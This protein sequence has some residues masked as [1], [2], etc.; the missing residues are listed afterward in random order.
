MTEHEGGQ[1]KKQNKRHV[2]TFCGEKQP[3]VVDVVNRQTAELATV[4]PRS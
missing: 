4:V 2:N 3:A 1:K